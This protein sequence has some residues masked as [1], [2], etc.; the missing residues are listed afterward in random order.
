MFIELHDAPESYYKRLE[1]RD[2][3]DEAHVT[4]RRTAGDSDTQLQIL[5]RKPDVACTLSRFTGLPFLGK[6]NS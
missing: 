5:L 4:F 6:H 2:Q 1:I 3:G